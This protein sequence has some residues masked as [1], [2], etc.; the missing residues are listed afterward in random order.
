MNKYAS[1]LDNGSDPRR[2]LAMAIG[3]LALVFALGLVLD[4][5]ACSA[6]GPA[7]G[8]PQGQPEPAAEAPA[9]Q[10]PQAPQQAPQG[11]RAQAGE[12]EDRALVRLGGDGPKVRNYSRLISLDE[13]RDALAEPVARALSGIGLD[14]ASATL[15]VPR[16][17]EIDQQGA[18]CWFLVEGADAALACT[19]DATSGAWSAEW[20]QET[21]AGVWEAPDEPAA[22]GDGTAEGDEGSQAA[23]GGAEQAAPEAGE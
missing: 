15:D 19:Y 17:P 8:A 10:E 6:E 5:V 1:F 3:A 16:D 18:V 7:G 11:E 14:P 13:A 23:D 21:V 12:D 20:L 4:A 2:K 9:D 22:D